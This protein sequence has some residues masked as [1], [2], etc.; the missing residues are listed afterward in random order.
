VPGTA[1]GQ[2][3]T[4][5]ERA[6]RQLLEPAQVCRVDDDLEVD[7]A[8]SDEARAQLGGSVDEVAVLWLMSAFGA[9]IVTELPSCSVPRRRRRSPRGLAD[10]AVAPRGIVRHPAAESEVSK[11]AAPC[12]D[13]RERPRFPEVA[14]AIMEDLEDEMTG[15]RRP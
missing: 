15:V 7:K 5:H 2:H 8:P 10:H 3:R 14:T 9:L 12:S 4:E 6:L 13:D 11:A 1:P